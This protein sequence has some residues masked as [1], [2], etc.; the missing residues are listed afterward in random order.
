MIE[1]YDFPAEFKNEHIVNAFKDLLGHSNFDLKWVDDTHCLGVFENAQVAMDALK[2]QH[3]MLKARSISQATQASKKK[4]RG[5][6][7]YM[8]PYKARPQTT[9]F[10]ASKLIAS[11]LGIKSSMSKEKAKEERLKIETAKGSLFFKNKNSNIKGFI[12]F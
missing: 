11:S 4:A 9:S 3:M 2:I 12:F 10:V 1:I 5:C 6:V 8:K 7:Q